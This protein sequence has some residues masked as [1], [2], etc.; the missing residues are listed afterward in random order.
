MGWFV[1][2]TGQNLHP[3][4]PSR[5][6]STRIKFTYVSRRQGMTG[7]HSASGV[8]RDSPV[9]VL[10]HRPVWVGYSTLHVLPGRDGPLF[11][12]GTVCRCVECRRNIFL[13]VQHSRSPVRVLE[14]WPKS[15]FGI[16]RIVIYGAFT[17]TTSLHS[18]NL[19]FPTLPSTS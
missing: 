7:R 3:T 14:F 11:S 19:P 10:G 13:L 4:C 16:E 6:F 2:G 12:R 1:R 5:S 17:Y 9:R 8:E 18:L 15:I